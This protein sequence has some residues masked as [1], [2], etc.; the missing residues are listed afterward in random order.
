M[1]AA[2]QLY[3]IELVLCIVSNVGPIECIIFTMTADFAFNN[4]G[5][6]L[7]LHIDYNQ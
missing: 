3:S 5:M 6:E 1:S 4:S 2:L 7:G